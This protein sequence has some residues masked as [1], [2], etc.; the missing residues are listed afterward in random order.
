MERRGSFRKCFIPSWKAPN[1]HFAY[2]SYR[3]R[4]AR[5]GPPKMGPRH[6]RQGC[7]R[8]PTGPEWPH[9]R[10]VVFIGPLDG[11]CKVSR[12]LELIWYGF[13]PFSPPDW[14]LI[15][16]V[17]GPSPLGSCLVFLL[18]CSLCTFDTFLELSRHV[19]LQL[20]N[21]QNSWNFLNYEPYF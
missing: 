6:A 7:G 12:H 8:T 9:L 16:L 2:L 15:C 13:W 10:P 20:M 11:L 3:H 17:S 5:G 14:A 19:L 4:P 1:R 21:H 18:L